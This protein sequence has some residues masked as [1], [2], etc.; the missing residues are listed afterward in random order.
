MGNTSKITANPDYQGFDKKKQ[1][2]VKE[3]RSTTKGFSDD[4]AECAD[5]ATTFSYLAR[6]GFR[7]VSGD[8]SGGSA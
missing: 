4:V 8:D 2:V 1:K 3:M 6:Y 7:D 5:S